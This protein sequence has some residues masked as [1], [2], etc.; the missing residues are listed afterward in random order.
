MS[1]CCLPIRGRADA[2]LVQAIG[3]IRHAPHHG[4][5]CPALLVL[6]LLGTARKVEDGSI[7]VHPPR[8]GT[9]AAAEDPLR[10][11]DA[12]CLVRRGHVRL[13]APMEPREPR[14]AQA[15][16]EGSA[17][18]LPRRPNP[19]PDERDRHHYL[20]PV[21]EDKVLDFLVQGARRFQGP[22]ARVLL[23]A[24][25]LT[26]PLLLSTRD[27]SGYGLLSGRRPVR[28]PDHLHDGPGAPPGPLEPPYDAAPKGAQ[29]RMS[30]CD[31]PLRLG[32][33][34]TI[35]QRPPRR[36][37]RPRPARAFALGASAIG[38]AGAWRVR[39]RMPPGSARLFVKCFT[40]E[41]VLV[42]RFVHFRDTVSQK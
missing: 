32:D 21:P 29:T 14:V 38:P 19:L 28:L 18:D 16:L 34:S 30:P 12:G 40:L 1:Q 39:R 11:R 37:G 15:S 24:A 31:H 26:G 27:R 23:L 41:A 35:P 33:Y 10:E 8:E 3:P 13:P 22:S 42:S 20:A 6:L 2:L 25:P 17:G 5:E 9:D 7:G 36:L 4:P